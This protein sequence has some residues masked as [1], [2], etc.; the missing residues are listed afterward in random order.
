MRHN[1]DFRES[2]LIDTVRRIHRVLSSLQVPYAV[3]GGMAVLKNGA[4][5]TT[6]D[7]DLL[8]DKDCWNRLR[9]SPPEEFDLQM[10]SAV[11]LSNGIEIDVLF[12]GDDW[13]MVIS[14]PDPEKVREYDVG[15][16]AYF[17]DLLH[18]LE[19]K[20]A[21]FIKKRDEDGLEIAAKDLADIVALTEK[22]G[23][24]ISPEFIDRMRK[25]VRGEYEK[26]AKKILK[27]GNQ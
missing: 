17:I 2:P 4:A 6:L 13:A 20:T 15:L 21:V 27:R 16:E 24:K 14:M 7:V 18:L 5:R 19:M 22:N 23:E 10:D 1:G 12:P 26:I 8:V 11:D 25:E 9:E 3:I